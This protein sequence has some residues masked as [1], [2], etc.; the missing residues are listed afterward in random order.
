MLEGIRY[1]GPEEAAHG[2][3]QST[4]IPEVGATRE[5]AATS[6]AYSSAHGRAS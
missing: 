4:K 1:S 2:G 6:E 3:P 5:Q